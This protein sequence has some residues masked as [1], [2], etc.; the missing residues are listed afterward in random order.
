VKYALLMYE[1]E[2]IW[3]SLSKEGQGQIFSE[4]GSLTADFA[5][6]AR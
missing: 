2:K 1:A 4:Y 5:K 6:S 3:A